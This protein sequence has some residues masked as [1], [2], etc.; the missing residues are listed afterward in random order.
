L[1]SLSSQGEGDAGRQ[2]VR[3][4]RSLNLETQQLVIL[5][6]RLVSPSPPGGEGDAGRQ[7]VRFTRMPWA[8]ARGVVEGA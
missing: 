4:T 8:S 3:F 7:R 5:M 2:R 6:D 1:V